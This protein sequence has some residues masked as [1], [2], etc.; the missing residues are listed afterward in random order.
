[1]KCTSLLIQDHNVIRRALE[2]LQAMAARTENGEAVE[3]EDVQKLLRF[4]R[5]FADDYHQTKE[6]SALFP[7]LVR[8]S[9]LNYEPL[10]HMIFEHDQERSLVEGLEDALCTK[11]GS[12]FVYFANRLMQLL[13][14]HIQNE[15]DVMFQM[16]DHSLSDEQDEHIVSQFGK[17]KVQPGVVADLQHLEWTYLRKTGCA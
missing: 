16:A 6:E 17:F 13:S 10:R 2:V 14:T 12:E 5:T 8:A 15:E 3:A 9:A 11:K 7:E 1:M 4:L